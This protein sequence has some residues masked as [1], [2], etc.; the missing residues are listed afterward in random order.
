MCK[1]ESVEGLCVAIRVAEGR[2]QIFTFKNT[3][4]NSHLTFSNIHNRIRNIPYTHTYT[5]IHTYIHTYTYTYIH[6]CTNKHTHTYT[7]TLIHINTHIHAHTL[8]HTHIHTHIYTHI[9][10]HIQIRTLT[11]IHTHI[12]IYT[13]TYTH[14]HTHIHIHIHTHINTHT[15][16][17][18]HTHK[19]THTAAMRLNV[20]TV[21]LYM[22]HRIWRIFTVFHSIFRW[23]RILLTYKLLWLLSTYLTNTHSQI[24]WSL[25]RPHK[26]DTIKTTSSFFWGVC[27]TSK[28][29]KLRLELSRFQ[30]QMGNENF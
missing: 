3:N 5:R 22:L 28:S 14:I 26:T 7:Y 27:C 13:H 30:F 24:F 19:H 8:I 4:E 29:F 12:Y 23:L 25:L 21:A 2:S 6:T 18:T 20:I 11:Q 1:F 9:R 15:H 10:T 17:H 16:I